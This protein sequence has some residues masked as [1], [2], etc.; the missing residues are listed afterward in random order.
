MGKTGEKFFGG[1]ER[2]WSTFLKVGRS[3]FFR[4]RALYHVTFDYDCS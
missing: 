3:S 4:R 1:N 2:D